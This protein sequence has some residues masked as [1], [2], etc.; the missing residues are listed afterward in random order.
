VSNYVESTLIPG[1]RVLHTG[2]VSLWS[3]FPPLLVGVAFALVLGPAMAVFL[4]EGGHPNAPRL[5]RLAVPGILFFVGLFSWLMAFVRYNST[6][7]AITNM[8][9]I[10]KFGF[11]SRRTIEM[12]VDKI[13][14]LQVM[15]GVLG[16]IFGFGTLIVVG[17]GFS[18]EPI[19]NISDPLEYRRL[20]ME[21]MHASQAGE[22]QHRSM[23]NHE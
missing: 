10:A 15:Q 5:F 16:R 3:L 6:E 12:N 9:I 4:W 17:A 19:P 2:H 8:R 7:I 14:S 13:V 22:A 20:L 1:E 21:A 11:V 18:Q 23:G